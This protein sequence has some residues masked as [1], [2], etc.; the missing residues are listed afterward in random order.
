MRL[1]TVVTLGLISILLV[2][3]MYIYYPG[4]TGGFLLDDKSVLL[5]LQLINDQISVENIINYI[6]ASN[7]GP[8]KRPLSV[9]SFLFDAQNWPAEP[10]SFKRTNV[11]LHG[12]NGVLLFLLLSK[13]FSLT[14]SSKWIKNNHLLLAFI[15][16]ALW[17]FNPFLVSTTLYVVQRMTMLSVTF[18]LIGLLI[19]LRCRSQMKAETLGKKLHLVI[20]VYAAVTLSV[21][22]K[23]NGVLLFI[24]FALFEFLLC[25]K[26]LKFKTLSP[27]IK[28]YLFWLPISVLV[29]YVLIKTPSYLAN[30]DVRPFSMGER[31]LS[32]SRALC[33]YLYHLF[34]PHYFTEGVFTDG[35]SKST[36]IFSPISTFI[37]LCF[38]ILLAGFSWIYKNKFTWISF[39]LL[40]FLAAHILESTFVPLELYFEHRN[41][42][43]S[44]FLFVPISLLLVYVIQ[45]SKIYY[46]IVI[47]V[48]G[49]FAVSTLQRA[50]I[51]GNQI[52]LHELSMK[53]FPESV[54]A[55]TLTALQYQ[56]KGL[57]HDA[58]SIIE[59][60]LDHLD[61]NELRMN[62][63]SMKC[64]LMEL[65]AADIDNVIT[66]LKQTQFTKNDIMPFEAMID[67]LLKDQCNY[68]ATNDQVNQVLDHFRSNVYDRSLYGKALYHYLMGKFQLLR[69]NDSKKA[70]ENFIQSY[71]INKDLT[72]ALINLSELEKAEAFEDALNFSTQIKQ[73]M[74]KNKRWFSGDTK[75]L[76]ID[77][78]IKRLASNKSHER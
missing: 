28:W 7:T 20:I 17:L 35:F 18:V 39:S 44:M 70:T 32:E 75:L 14:A 8:L 60:G 33:L 74:L 76:L 16:S 12:I 40:F 53:Q 42:T 22:S 3:N 2:V 54:R 47:A 69:L 73:I 63:V 37:S 1:L 62:V 64:F 9:L 72:T 24:F 66:S 25:Q 56:N 21:L 46:L 19:Y 43:A 27:Q 77:N 30:Y 6:S 10:L 71:I 55:R 50:H 4:F 68:R 67:S 11:I 34:I 31:L 48:L 13:S 23:E 5:K 59:G 29:L 36:G 51:W 78:I 26:V 57:H 15:A 58:L 38:L 61:H 65:T 45:Q 41:Y 49:L 52:M